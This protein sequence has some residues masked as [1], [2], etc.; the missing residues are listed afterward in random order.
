MNPVSKLDRYPIPKI[1]DLFAK[2]SGV[3]TFTKIYLSQAYQQISLDEESQ[4]YVVINTH[5]GL[6]KYTR[7]PFRISPAPSIYQRVMESVLQEFLG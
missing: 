5:K 4:K 6:F 2:L 7:L 1:E 3:L